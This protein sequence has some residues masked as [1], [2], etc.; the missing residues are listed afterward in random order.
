LLSLVWLGALGCASGGSSP[1]AAA[2]TGAAQAR[3]APQPQLPALEAELNAAVAA[4][5]KKRGLSAL[6]P[7]LL[8]VNLARGHSEA[9]ATGDRSFGH[10]AFGERRDAVY[11]GLPANRVAE[12]VGYT[13]ETEAGAAAEIVE[14][15]LN[16]PQHRDQMLGSFRWGGAAAARNEQGTLFFTLLLAGP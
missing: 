13:E 16:S 7:S 10:D 6:E 9:M 4:E 5:R 1:A 3:L 15:W 2:A 14:Y 11:E 8:L 12:N